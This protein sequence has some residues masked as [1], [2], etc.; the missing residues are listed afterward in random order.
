MTRLDRYILA[1]LL[2]VFGFFSLVL[3]SVY[4]VNRAVR[5]F[6]QLISDGQPMSVF[7]EFTA[8]SLPMLIR[9]VLPI[10]AFVAATYVTYQLVRNS[11]IAVLQ[12]AGI[13]PFRIARPIVVF[14]LIVA[15]F[16]T[17]LMNF[18]IPEA[19]AELSRRQ[20]EVAQNLTAG[21]LQDG[22][23]QHPADGITFF[24]T[25]ITPEGAMR[26]IYLSDAR[27][28]LQRIDYTARTALIVPED[29]GPKLVMIDG[30]AQIHDRRTGRLSV[31]GFGDFTYDLSA[32]AG[33]AG[34]GRS[35]QELPT[36]SLFSPSPALLAETGASAAQMRFELVSRFVDGFAAVAAAL[37]GF[38]ALMA[39]GFSR[40]GFWK[41]IVLAVVLMAL[42]QTLNNALAG[43]AMRDPALSWLGVVPLLLA[44]AT[45]L[46]LVGWSTRK[47]RVRA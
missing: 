20:S 5:L 9:T 46:G 38:G 18:L 17:V 43:T 10:S 25:E 36:T 47:R 44:V 30:Q 13:S 39:G 41:E 29:T 4:W 2:W 7:L 32:L 15:A 27:S 11:E 6:D 33:P 21:L 24:I 34:R 3:V 37:I 8:L 28:Q 35:V 42:V 45:A 26:G 31:T 16:L 22:V 23:F 14:G 40:L 1:Q 12:A 19:R